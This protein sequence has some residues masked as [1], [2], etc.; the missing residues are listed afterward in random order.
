MAYVDRT[1]PE[2]AKRYRERRKKE[3]EA[4][5]RSDINPKNYK[6]DLPVQVW[7]DSRYLATMSNYL[8]EKGV[9]TRFLSEVIRETLEWIVDSLVEQGQVNM[10]DD[11]MLARDIIATKYR[12][13]LN[14]SGRGL[15][16]LQHN[17]VLTERR[18][19]IIS[20][21]PLKDFRDSRIYKDDD[22]DVEEVRRETEEQLRK[23][24]AMKK[25]AMDKDVER[26]KAAAMND[27]RVVRL[28]GESETVKS[29]V[30]RNLEKMKKADEALE[31]F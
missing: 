22:I 19:S 25:E 5:G 27:P 29:N 14:S 9:Q 11:T 30:D 6:G 1:A 4:R 16:N 12:I 18:R 24:E 31:R 2:R 21:Q 8:D 10:I 13:N 28:E 3:D 23:I 15:K 26:Q 20:N 7:L 17:M